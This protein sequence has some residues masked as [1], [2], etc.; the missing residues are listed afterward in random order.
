MS[1]TDLRPAALRR[2]RVMRRNGIVSPVRAFSAARKANLPLPIACA[3]LEQESAGGQNVFGHDDTIFAGAGKVTRRKYHRYKR[4]R[5]ALLPDGGR[6][7]QG[8]GP[9][10]LTWYEFQDRAD[11]RGGCHRPTRNMGVGFDLV[12]AYLDDSDGNLVDAGEKFNGARSYG[13]EVK[14]KAER[15]RQRLP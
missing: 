11:E 12:R 1:T 3:F 15:W 7:M 2:I 5:D 9:M 8:V 6:R 14:A 4:L 13:H 10:Q